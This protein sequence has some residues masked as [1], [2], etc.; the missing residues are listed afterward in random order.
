MNGKQGVAPSSRAWTYAQLLLGMVIFGSGTPVSKLVT[1]AFPPFLASGLRMMVGALV[2]LP[3]LV[4]RREEIRQLR[5]REWGYLGLIALVGMFGFSLLM[6]YGMKQVSGVLGSIVM[7]TTP[8]VTGIAAYLFLREHLGWRKLVAILLAVAGVLLVNTVGKSAEQAGGNLFVGSLLVFGAVCGEAAYT[9]MGKVIMEQ[10]KPLLVAGL[11]SGMAVLLFL[12]PAGYEAL[13]FDF[14][15]PQWQ[16]WLALFWWGAG[17][18]ALG[19]VFWYRGVEQVPGTV[20]AGFMGVMPVSALVLSYLLLGEP[21]RW[22]HLVGFGLVFAGV[23]F[24]AWSHGH[25]AHQEEHGS[26][27]IPH[28]MH[29]GAHSHRSA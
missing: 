5:W 20:A 25:Q 1:S 19:T 15:K 6:L 9:L 24:I 11:A 26:E 17:T 12:A 10:V 21:F 27:E 14:G 28:A 29:A 23:M 2:L 3:F 16:N 22:I 13:H 8:A 7:S 4:R 18:L